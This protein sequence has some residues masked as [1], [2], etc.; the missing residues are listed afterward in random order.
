MHTILDE[1]MHTYI[2][3][4]YTHIH[5]IKTME[6]NLSPSETLFTLALFTLPCFVEEFNPD[7]DTAWDWFC[8][9]CNSKGM[10]EDQMNVF[11]NVFFTTKNKIKKNKNKK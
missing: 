11:D 9:T 5:S 2:S 6:K 3:S 1:I 8:N 7:Y 4:R 10:Y